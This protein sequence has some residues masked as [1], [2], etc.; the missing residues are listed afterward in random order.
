[1]A[2]N[3]VIL[4]DSSPVGQVPNT[5]TTWFTAA[6]GLG[7]IAVVRYIHVY[8]PGSGTVNFTLSYGADAAGTRLFDAYP[9][10]EDT[11]LAHWLALP[12]HSSDI[13]QVTG[14]VNNQLVFSMT[15]QSYLTAINPAT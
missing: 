10:A 7:V 2:N 5:P 9:I 8:N 13:V 12:L 14:S 3:W 11:V 1:L 6:T 4:A 15:G